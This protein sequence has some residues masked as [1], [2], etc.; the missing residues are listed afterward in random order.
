[1]AKGIEQIMDELRN[2]KEDLRYIKNNMPDKEMFL[3]SEEKSLLK[4]S[5][6]HEKESALISSKDLKK[7][8][9]I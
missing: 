4:G 6:K 9:G 5:F 8:L 3:N 1:M 7:K 2:I